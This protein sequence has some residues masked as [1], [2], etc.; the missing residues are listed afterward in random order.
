[1]QYTSHPTA[2]LA[3]RTARRLLIVLLAGIGG[4]ALA[5]GPSPVAHS[6]LQ[7]CPFTAEE[8]SA[9]TGLKVEMVP[10]MSFAGAPK[11][12]T[13]PVNGEMFLS[14]SATDGG[15]SASLLVSQRWFDPKTA[16]ARIKALQLRDLKAAQALPGDA[17]GALWLSE[18]DGAKQALHYVRGGN[19]MVMVSVDGVP[20]RLATDLQARL[21]KLRRVP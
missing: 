19:V 7:R 3:G 17:D 1:M 2:T 10:L 18:R 12:M 14:C 16:A 11:P 15:A 20:K 6:Q 8:L 13:E 5:A 9:A 4:P 21:T